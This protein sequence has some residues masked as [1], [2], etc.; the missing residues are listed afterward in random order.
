MLLDG[1]QLYR[2]IAGAMNTRQDVFGKLS[3]APYPCPLLGHTNM[4]LVDNRSPLWNSKIGVPPHVGRLGMPH[5]RAKEVRLRIL[6]DSSRERRKSLGRGL[7][8]VLV[9]KHEEL[10]ILSV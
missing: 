9:P 7:P 2:V 6:D 1:H 10:E 3:V 8:T 4:S 5:L